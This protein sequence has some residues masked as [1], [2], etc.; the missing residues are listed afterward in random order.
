MSSRSLF[1]LAAVVAFGQG[2]GAAANSSAAPQLSADLVVE[3]ADILISPSPDEPSLEGYL[4]IWNGTGQS[5]SITEVRSDAFGEIEFVQ[6]VKTR[7]ETRTEIQES[8]SIPARSELLMRPGG[9]YLLIDPGSKPPRV[10]GQVNMEIFY[11][12]GA[13][14]TIVA[15]VSAAGTVLEDHH[16]GM[17]PTK[18][19]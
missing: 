2:L 4:V 19:L 11:A 17:P 6:T 3:H 5:A 13:S 10:G 14:E 18:P 7:A 12:D 8:L 9:V 1:K 15:Q 16:H